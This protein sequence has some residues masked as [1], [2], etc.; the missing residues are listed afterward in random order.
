[1]PLF[2]SEEDELEEPIVIMAGMSRKF[3]GRSPKQKGEK[4]DFV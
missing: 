1:M 3:S 2:I 4:E